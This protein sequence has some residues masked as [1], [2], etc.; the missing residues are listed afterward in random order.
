MM[1]AYVI[2]MNFETVV[3]VGSFQPL[4]QFDRYLLCHLQL[5]KLKT[6][7]HTDT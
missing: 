3:H 4:T 6:N 5:Q 7:A 1:I 2:L